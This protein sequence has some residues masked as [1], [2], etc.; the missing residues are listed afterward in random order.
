MVADMVKI[1]SAE[2]K[3]NTRITMH[4]NNLFK[5]VFNG[6]RVEDSVDCSS[7]FGGLSV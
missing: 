6:K 2:K 5:E 3:D 1:C 4:S 7:C